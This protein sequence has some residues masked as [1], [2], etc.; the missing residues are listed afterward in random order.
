MHSG[1]L[2]INEDGDH[3]LCSQN[4]GHTHDKLDVLGLVTEGIHTQDTSNAAADGSH[5]KQRSF[6]NTP[7]VFLGFDF[8]HKHKQEANGI[9]YSKID[10]YYFEQH[11]NILSEGD[12][13]EKMVCCTAD[14]SLTNRLR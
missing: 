10:D 5:K 7:K 4:Q 14:G 8:I 3:N 2:C 11:N 6:R 13:H 1:F 9:D 12:E